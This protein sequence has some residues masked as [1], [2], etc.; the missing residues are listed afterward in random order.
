MLADAPT[1]D[2]PQGQ[3]VA[4]AVL[5]KWPEH[6]KLSLG[7]PTYLYGHEPP[8]V[9]CAAQ[10]KF[11]SNAVREDV[12]VLTC[13]SGI[14]FCPGSAGTRTEIAQFAVPQVYSAETKGDFSKPMIFF[15]NFW[16]ENTMYQTCL[17]LA[18]REQLGAPRPSLHYAT[19]MYQTTS[20]AATVSIVTEFNAKYYP[21]GDVSRG[22]APQV[23][24]QAKL[25]QSMPMLLRA[26]APAGTVE[27]AKKA[28]AYKAVEDWV[29]RDGMVIGIGAGETVEFAVDRLA[30]LV[31]AHGW[32][33]IVCVPTSFASRHLLRKYADVLLVCD[34]LTE[35]RDLGVA[36]DGADATD[37]SLRLVKGSGGALLCEK[38]IAQAAK[39]YIV[40]ADWRKNSATLVPV[41]DDFEGGS[42]GGAVPVEVKPL[43]WKRVQKSIKQTL[44]VASELKVLVSSVAGTTTP[45]VTDNGHYILDVQLRADQLQTTRK[46]EMGGDTVSDTLR[47]LHDIAGV[48]QVG[49]LEHATTAAYFG[50]ED[51]TVKIRERVVTSDA[52]MLVTAARQHAALQQVLDAVECHRDDPDLVASGLKPVEEI[53]LDMCSLMPYRR[54]LASLAEAGLEWGIPE[55]QVPLLQESMRVLPGYT[56]AAW[57][58]W[59]KEPEVAA[60]KNAHPDLPWTADDKNK[61]TPKG[62]PG[63]TV[64]SAFHL[65]FWAYAEEMEHD[66]VTPGLAEF[67][68]AVQARGGTVVF[69][70]GRWKPDMARATL[71]ALRRARL[72][73]EPN[74]VIGNKFHDDPNIKMSDADA[75]KEAQKVIRAKYGLPV[76]MFDDRKS[77]LDAVASLNKT[78]LVASDF[79]SVVSC[80][81]GYSSAP[82]A[83]SAPAI[84]NFFLNRIDPRA[85]PGSAAAAAAAASGPSLSLGDTA[86]LPAAPRPSRML[87]NADPSADVAPRAAVVSP[88]VPL[89]PGNSSACSVSKQQLLSVDHAC[90]V[91]SQ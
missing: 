53:D 74:L 77:N 19:K 14:V 40:I 71:I 36:F 17:N 82:I 68:D 18:Q 66:V 31:D 45:F 25:D 12:L 47:A 7:I 5:K 1:F 75:K 60:I 35:E 89:T 78:G 15:G 59:L 51:G 48:V 43:A 23:A 87:L 8:N 16:T 32:K 67:E 81:P 85:G 34:M 9:C 2:Q 13:N 49:L 83:A 4:L 65:R 90:L 56:A 30:Q 33:N 62:Q 50:Q 29:N 54:T 63:A 10:A 44:G 80:I 41:D 42:T 73:N 28:A 86:T 79:I 72:S 70:S 64:H 38:V 46:E 6:N 69:V 20:R 3:A 26:K 91:G 11:F 55:L 88:A 84:S 39:Y 76:A 58:E 61:D 27:G 21:Y 52:A 22:V 24:P 37:A 57:N